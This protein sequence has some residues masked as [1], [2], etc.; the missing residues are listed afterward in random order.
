MPTTIEDFMKTAT[1]EQKNL[2]FSL[3][4]T[5]EEE[6]KYVNEVNRIYKSMKSGVH[7]SDG[8]SVTPCETEDD[9][10]IISIGPRQELKR[11]REQMKK[12]LEEAV[13]LG[14]GHLGIVQ[15]NYEHY[16]GKPLPK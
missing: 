11:V 7:S 14:M 9:A 16:V 1:E 12:Y 15:R 10:M 13:G 8:I 5:A 2:L 3:A 6:K 4:E